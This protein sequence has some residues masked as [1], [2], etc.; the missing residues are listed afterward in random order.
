MKTTK[1]FLILALTGFMAKAQTTWQIDKVH[2]TVRFTIAHMVIS[3]I[4]GY[5]TD[6]NGSISYEKNDLSD[7][8]VNFT[9]NTN[10]VNTRNAKRDGHL[11]SPDFFDAAKYPTIT[12]KSTS[13]TQKDAKHFTLKGNLTMHGVIKPVVLDLFAAGTIKDNRGNLKAGFKVT[14]N[15]KR[16]DFG[17]KY[18]SVMDNGGVVIG[19]EVSFNIKLETRQSKK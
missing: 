19:K 3:E 11:R 8:V 9:I 4:D 16:S 17:L 13:V 18:N 6:F 7:A 1:L 5:F 12:F 2:S 15:L 14:G 10:S